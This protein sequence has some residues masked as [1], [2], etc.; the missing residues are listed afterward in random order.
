MAI[1]R[2]ILISAWLLAL[3]A[4]LM[5]GNAY[6]HGRQYGLLGESGA[7]ATRGGGIC[8]RRITYVVCSSERDCAGNSKEHCSGICR[9]CT[10]SN[11]TEEL[12]YSPPYNVHY[13]YDLINDP[14]GCGLMYLRPGG[15]AGFG[16][17]VWDETRGCVCPSDLVASGELQCRQRTYCVD[18]GC[19]PE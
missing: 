10:V 6:L 5:A 15:G 17:C 1:L 13:Y 14:V 3:V 4:W 11:T 8:D 2:R 19:W 7:A 9:K 12:S 18:C 16:N